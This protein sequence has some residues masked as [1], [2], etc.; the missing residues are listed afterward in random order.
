MFEVIKHSSC[1]F[2]TPVSMFFWET[3]SRC[4]SSK[5]FKVIR[6]NTINQMQV[7][8]CLMPLLHYFLIINFRWKAVL[9]ITLCMW[10]IQS[11]LQRTTPSFGAAGKCVAVVVT[12]AT[13][14]DSDCFLID[15]CWMHFM[16]TTFPETSFRDGL[17]GRMS[18]VE[19][20][21]AEFGSP[22]ATCTRTCTE[23]AGQTA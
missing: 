16:S 18:V 23:L 14:L 7:T 6:D 20:S 9:F 22:S 1:Y 19:S 13:G 2:L 12:V 8:S 11:L 15:V 4:L 10:I 5:Y 3:V 17:Q 21:G